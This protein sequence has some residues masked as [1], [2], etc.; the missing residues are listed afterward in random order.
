MMRYIHITKWLEHQHYKDRRPKWIK[1]YLDMIEEFDAD[2]MPKPFYHLPDSAKLSY[3]LLVCLRAN[4]NKHIPFPNVGWLKWRLGT[5]TV[6]L[7]P[8]IDAE[9]ISIS[10][11]PYQCDTGL[12]QDYT[13]SLPPETKT[14]GEKEREQE[15][16]TKA[17]DF[18]NNSDFLFNWL[19]NELQFQ[20]PHEKNTFRKYARELIQ[21][22]NWKK[23]NIHL[24]SL[25]LDLKEEI[26][27]GKIKRVNMMK[28]LNHA[29][30]Q[31]LK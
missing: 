31:K 15:T 13:E 20:T 28:I 19:D 29:I 26:K 1:L 30:Q 2:G 23:I 10:T 25:I 27:L 5:D 7:Q 11:E 14:K 12:I 24:S 4:Y 6:N 9:L 22:P 21:L 18:A 16:K 8:L 17:F 3:L